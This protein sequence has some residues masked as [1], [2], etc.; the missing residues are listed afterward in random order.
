M[1]VRRIGEPGAER[2]QIVLNL[3]RAAPADRA[4]TPARAHGAE[5]GVELVDLAVGVDAR[6]GLRHARAV[7]QRRLAG[8]AGLV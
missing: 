4:S 7:E 2:E 5:A 8:V 1:R 3:S 6:I